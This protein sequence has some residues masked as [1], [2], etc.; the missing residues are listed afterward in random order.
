MAHE[1]TPEELAELGREI[2]LNA[3]AVA[4]GTVQEVADKLTKMAVEEAVEKA[5]ASVQEFLT[6][7]FEEHHDQI[8]KQVEKTCERV[9]LGQSALGRAGAAGEMLREATTE[10]QKARAAMEELRE[11]FDKRAEQLD[12]IRADAIGALDKLGPIAAQQV[13][14][15]LEERWEKLCEEVEALKRSERA[16]RAHV[17]KALEDFQESAEEILAKAEARLRAGLEE[18]LAAGPK[19]VDPDPGINIMAFRGPWDAEVTYK[20]GDVVIHE[21]STWI[22]AGGTVGVDPEYSDG[23]DWRLMRMG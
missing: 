20:A 15:A 2:R 12:T 6:E 22:A 13:D 7:R 17:T 16:Q 3:R 23:V 4:A 8:V 10:S 1:I 18:K 11:T 19:L 14:T 9:L 21:G 5:K